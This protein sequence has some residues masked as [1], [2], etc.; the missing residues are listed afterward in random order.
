MS[1]FQKSVKSFQI[2]S[3]LSK[4]GRFFLLLLYLFP[5]FCIFR[6]FYL[7]NYQIIVIAFQISV[8]EVV[9][10]TSRTMESE[11]HAAKH[12][13]TVRKQ[14]KA[15][16]DKDPEKKRQCEKAKYHADPEKKRQ[17]EKAKYDTD[18][19]KKRQREKA[20]YHADPLS[21]SQ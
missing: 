6:Y 21:V 2:K 17:H 7:P 4:K 14:M 3:F 8:A 10:N 18:P 20:K 19:E 15:T 1:S 12:R 5:I 13:E 11:E 9:I 16:Y